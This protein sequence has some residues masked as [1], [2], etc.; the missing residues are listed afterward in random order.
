[1]KLSI[2]FVAVSL[3]AL[4]FNVN[5]ANPTFNHKGIQKGAIS[6]SC[7]RD[8]CLVVKVM[9]FEILKKT[10]QTTSIKLNVVGG[11]RGW[12]A[13]N[14]DWNHFFHDLYITCSIKKPTVQIGDQV[15]I[16]PLNPEGVPGVLFSDAQLYIQTCHNYFGDDYKAA[17]KYGYNVSY[18]ESI[19]ESIDT[20]TILTKLVERALE[21]F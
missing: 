13:K 14:T 21:W 7:Y 3:C 2:G 12:D 1:M 4:T 15:T 10:P 18:D 16:L 5:A 20:N 8:P 17:K 19:S 6:E 9:K 11:Y